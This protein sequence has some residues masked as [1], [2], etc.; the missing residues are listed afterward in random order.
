MGGRSEGEG[1]DVFFVSVFCR[2]L[3]G[4]LRVF[5]RVVG[6]LGEERGLMAG[7]RRKKGGEEDFFLNCFFGVGCFFRREQEVF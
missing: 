2:L 6:F 5:L 4:L 7:G 1:S 3:V